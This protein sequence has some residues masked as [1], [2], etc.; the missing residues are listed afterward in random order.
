MARNLQLNARVIASENL[1]M[2]LARKIG[3]TT[4]HDLV[5]HAVLHSD[6]GADLTDTLLEN[7]QVS[8]AMSRA[9]MEAALVPARYLGD[10]IEIA[11]KAAALAAATATAMRSRSE[12]WPAR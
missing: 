3:R 4:A 8:A 2:I 10:S 6:D 11:R 9:E 7:S 5:H 12:A 1:M